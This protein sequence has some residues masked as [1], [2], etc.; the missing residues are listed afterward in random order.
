AMRRI[1]AEVGGDIPS[2][3]FLASESMP[4]ISVRVL[5][6]PRDR[7]SEAHSAARARASFRAVAALAPAHRASGWEI[8]SPG[9]SRLILLKSR[10][11]LRLRVCRQPAP[12]S[13]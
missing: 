11:S 9:I 6:T 10:R 3:S 5:E 13:M 4:D 8:I 7:G 12:A 2:C 1:D